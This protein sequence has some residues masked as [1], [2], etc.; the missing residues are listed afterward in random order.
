MGG[1]GTRTPPINLILIV[2]LYN[3]LLVI[4]HEIHKCNDSCWYVYIILK[5]YYQI[6]YDFYFFFV[7]LNRISTVVKSQ[8][9]T[10]YTA[11]GKLMIVMTNSPP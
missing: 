10:I 3:V 8:V 11:R 6:R 7:W 5:L 2:L 4:I 1:G 9:A